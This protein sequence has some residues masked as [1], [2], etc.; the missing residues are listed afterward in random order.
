MMMVEKRKKMELI[1]YQ[2]KILKYDEVGAF[3]HKHVDPSKYT[4]TLQ[5]SDPTD[6]SGADLVFVNKARPSL[7]RDKYSYVLFGGKMAHYVT[8]LESGTRLCL[9][10]FLK[11]KKS[12]DGNRFVSFK[13]GNTNEED[14]N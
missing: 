14:S 7:H 1:N 12:W 11:Y 9:V 5:L 3:Y 8:P 6:Y 2:T 10:M 4:F 13:T